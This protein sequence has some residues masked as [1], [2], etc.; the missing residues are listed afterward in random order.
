MAQEKSMTPGE[1]LSYL[2]H[3]ERKLPSREY[4]MYLPSH[5]H[6]YGFEDVTVGEMNDE[7]QRMLEFAGMGSFKADCQ[8][9]ELE[10]N[11]VGSTNPGMTPDKVVH[12]N[13]E[14][15]MKGNWKAIMATL[16]HEICH[17]VIHLYGIQP[18]VTWILET[19]TDLCTIYIGFGQIILDGYNT[20]VGGVKRALGYLDPTTYK[21]TCHMVSVVCGGVSSDNTGLTGYD[22]YADEAIEL[23]EK[24][25]DK[26]KLLLEAFK[27]K[28]SKLAEMQ[29]NICAVEQLASLYR[30]EAVSQTKELETKVFSTTYTKENALSAFQFIYESLL[31]EY[32]KSDEHQKIVNHCK[33]L[34]S[35]AYRLYSQIEKLQK[36]EFSSDFV[37]PGCG[38][39]MKSP[40]INDGIKIMKCNSCNTHFAV[41]TNQWVVDEKR[42]KEYMTKEEAKKYLET[43]KGEIESAFVERL[44]KIIRW[45][46]KKRL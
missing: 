25:D 12:I 10:G 29:R 24:E 1:I 7:C 26:R 41:D 23:W 17:H 38:K 28:S 18:M 37:C 5:R 39:R 32:D 2:C 36:V 4:K 42:E 43:G 40:A 35:V 3:L 34:D 31:V 14:R 44:P 15:N 9:T 30:N 21:L 16:A 46:A 45:V 33:T 19:Y 20:N 22:V 11:A 27:K 13:V 8:F 6:D